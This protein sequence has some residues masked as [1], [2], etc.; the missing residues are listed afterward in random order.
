MPD[1]Q[2]LTLVTSWPQA[3]AFV[4]LVVAVLVVPQVMAWVQAKRSAVTVNAVHKNLT[5]NNGGSHIKDQ[6]DRIEA[7]QA[8]QG[9]VQAQQGRELVRQGR[10]IK[11]VGDRL[12]AVEDHVTRPGG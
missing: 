3:V 8:E 7:A 10:A 4:A 6:L 1:A 2:T 9:L 5:T 11:A 12:A